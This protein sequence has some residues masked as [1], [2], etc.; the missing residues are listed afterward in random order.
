LSTG[1]FSPHHLAYPA[2]ITRASLPGIPGGGPGLPFILNAIEGGA[3][4]EWI[5]L[6]QRELGTIK[7]ATFPVDADDVHPGVEYRVNGL[8]AEMPPYLLRSYNGRAHD[9]VAPNVVGAVVLKNH[10]IELGAIMRGPFTNFNGTDYLVFAINRGAGARLSPALPSEPWIT[11]DALATLTIGPNG[12]TY[13]G[14]ITDRTTGVT[15]T[16]NPRDI[17]V[18][19]PVV[20]VLLSESQLQPEGWPVGKYRFA[21]WTESQLDPSISELAAFVPRTRMML[22]IGVETNVNSTMG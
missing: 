11:A 21:F 17:H 8:V 1:G 5:E 7:S 19:G 12:T 4:H 16:I 10:L 15:E 6:L 14:T 20:R 18:E 13:S 3:G 22:P 9:R 2:A